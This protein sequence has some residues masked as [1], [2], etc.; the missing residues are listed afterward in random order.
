MLKMLS[1]VHTACRQCHT[2]A[3][4][5][6]IEA[7]GDIITG[8][9]V[10]RSVEPHA[11]ER[12][13]GKDAICLNCGTA[14]IGNHCHNCGQH[15]HVHRTLSAFWRDF[16]HS[17][18][19]FEGKIW[20]TLPLLFFRPGQLTRRYVHGER[21]RFVSPLALFL[22]SIFLMAATFSWVG[23]PL[24]S[25]E[26]GNSKVVETGKADMTAAL[27]KA[28][29]KLV[30]LE[31]SGAS[32]KEIASIRED[33]F[34][35]ETG[36]KVAD[37]IGSNNL[38]VN[39]NEIHLGVPKIDDALKHAIKNPA[40]LLYKMQSNAYKF[41]WALIPISIPFVWLL[42]VF[43]R[44]YR[45]YDH[46]IFVTYSLSFMSLLLV[47]LS[48]LGR[49]GPLAGF[50]GPLIVF[51]P[52]AHMFFQLR[53]AYQISIFSAAWR[54]VALLGMAALVLILFGVLLLALGVAG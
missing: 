40:L 22:F 49:L 24:G 48:I 29:A 46:A 27:A 2:W 47:T 19:H 41:S 11:G 39:D 50:R 16:T 35:L 38:I 37:G 33:I 6:G 10:A 23:M 9:L 20:R 32:K 8:G 51:G 52:L 7:A 25:A 5:G 18:L 15:A 42:F 45:T 17:I 4:T 26:S 31:K 12:A 44:Q 13:A 34:G 3:M 53:G 28:R 43:R 30:M 36:I 54:T 21:A 1:R 14:V